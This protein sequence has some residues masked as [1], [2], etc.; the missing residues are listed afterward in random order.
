MKKRNYYFLIYLF[1]DALK[2]YTF[3]Q[4]TEYHKKKSS[5]NN[6]WKRTFSQ[7]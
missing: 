5:N 4:N 6:V 1:A 7:K 3:E 2:S